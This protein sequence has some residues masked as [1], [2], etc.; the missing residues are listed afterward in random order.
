MWHWKL[1][2]NLPV[3]TV[4]CNPEAFRHQGAP[5]ETPT[6]ISCLPAPPS[7]PS[8]GKFHPVPLHSISQAT[9]QPTSLEACCHQGLWGLSTP[10]AIRWLKANI[11]TQSIR[12][13]AICHYQNTAIVLQQALVYHN[14]A[15]AQ[16][17]DLNTNHVKIEEA[18][19]KEMKNIT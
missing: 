6:I 17:N 12:L 19:K 16:E 4:T 2:I 10:G 5:G 3:H 8:S 15:E 9:D 11:R 1:H 18:L 7:K 14:V 13:K